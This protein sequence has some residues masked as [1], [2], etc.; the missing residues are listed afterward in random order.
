MQ[1]TYTSKS[2]FDPVI[3][4]DQPLFKVPFPL[5]ELLSH[6]TNVSI[7]LTSGSFQLDF[8]RFT[9]LTQIVIQGPVS[10][11]IH[12]SETNKQMLK[13]LSI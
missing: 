2:V 6:I 11:Q 8:S 13:R 9:Q 12:F 10:P 1:N 5:K 7:V 4:P 3:P